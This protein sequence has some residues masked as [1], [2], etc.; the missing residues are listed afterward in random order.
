MPQQPR[1]RRQW[2]QL[3]LPGRLRRVG[4][5]GAAHMTSSGAK[6]WT[7]L[8]GQGFYVPGSGQAAKG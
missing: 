2:Q 6:G 8:Q 1:G 7:S 3:L 5:A 4:A